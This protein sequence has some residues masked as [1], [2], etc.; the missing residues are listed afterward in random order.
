M[1]LFLSVALCSQK[2]TNIRIF[3]E[4]GMNAHKINK[5]LTE[6]QKN[7]NF[8][9]KNVAKQTY[10]LDV[11]DGKSI[12]YKDKKMTLDINNK[13]DLIS[14]F[15][16]NGIYFHDSKTESTLNQKSV[17][18]EDFI[19]ESN[20]K[21]NWQLTQKQRKIANYTCFK[22]ITTEKFINRKGEVK[23]KQITAWY[24]PNISIGIGIK[25]YHGLPGAIIYLEDGN[26]YYNCTKIVINTKKKLKIKKPEK[27]TLITEKEYNNILKKDFIGKFGLKN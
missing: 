17:L 14:A 22:A 8:F 24:N 1:L 12:F 25:G 4:V 26:I 27:G 13:P 9:V 16:G 23:T 19:I 2:K 21:Y 11:F 3:Y 6:K 10:I 20:V 7:Y 18:G 5:D 15:V